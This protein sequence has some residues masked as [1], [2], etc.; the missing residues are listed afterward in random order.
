ML[1]INEIKK[2]I[3]ENLPH[4]CVVLEAGTAEGTDTVWLANYFYGGMI[5]GFEPQYELYA[6]T[7]ERVS[8]R[9]N[10]KLINAA[11]AE[12]NSTMQMHIADRF[13]EL[14]GSNS[15]L[16][17]KK[18]LELHPQITFKSTREVET[19]N[20]DSWAIKEEVTHIDFMWLD[21]QGYEPNTLKASPKL[22]KNTHYI[23]SEVCPIEN[24]EGQ[25]LYPE[26]KKMMEENGFVVVMEHIPWV[27]GGDVLFR[28]MNYEA[29]K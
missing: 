13:G 5:Y 1:P 2:W 22:L 12:T 16:A 21:M 14:W 26:Y 10:V 15:L 29:P 20:L 8:Y 17:P 3:P 23:W 9:S 7:L 18:H 27:D 19:I 28:N 11:L 24:Y 4:D 25:I 6:Q